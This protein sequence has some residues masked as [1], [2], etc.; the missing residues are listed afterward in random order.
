MKRL[1][2]IILI[3]ISSFSVSYAQFFGL[4]PYNSGTIAGQ[5]MGEQLREQMINSVD[6]GQVF[7]SQSQT[8]E[9]TNSNRRYSSNDE[10]KKSTFSNSYN[11]AQSS[12]PDRICGT[13]KGGGKCISCHGSGYRTDNYYGTG[14]DHSKKCGLCNG[15]G[16][17]TSCNGTGRR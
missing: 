13:C 8:T 12:K 9:S 6:W 14:V 17:C 2:I 7:N 15:K 10:S 16:T 4:Y 1:L 3:S 11:N 5:K